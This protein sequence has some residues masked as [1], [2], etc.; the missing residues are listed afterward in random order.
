VSNARPSLVGTLDRIAALRARIKQ[1]GRMRRNPK[2]ETLA[3]VWIDA[4]R[5]RLARELEA[6]RVMIA[7]GGAS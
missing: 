1:A 5:K 3:A 7:E 2:T 4:D 6:A